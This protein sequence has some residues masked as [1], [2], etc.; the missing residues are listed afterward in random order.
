[1]FRTAIGPNC[2]SHLHGAPI[3]T[4]RAAFRAARNAGP[5][6][7]SGRPCHAERRFERSERPSVPRGMPI[8]TVRSSLPRRAEC[9]SERSERPSAPRGT[10]VRTVR[11]AFRAARTAVSSVPNGVPCRA[12][13]GN[14]R[15]RP[16]GRPRVTS[17]RIVPR[18][19][20][21]SRKPARTPK[22]GPERG[23]GPSRTTARGAGPERSRL[24][25]PSARQI[26]PR[27]RLDRTPFV[28]T[29]KVRPTAETSSVELIAS[30]SPNGSIAGM[31]PRAYSSA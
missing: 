18:P 3:R 12:R 30:A 14:E 23:A 9:R 6:G 26:L 31:M 28:Y 25:T 13:A 11:A 24:D 4:V 5:N 10:R 15:R 7:P 1:M 2:R 29:A 17:F 19:R 22:P 20:T 21:P 8:R 16:R 27:A